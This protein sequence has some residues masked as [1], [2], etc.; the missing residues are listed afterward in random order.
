MEEHVKIY[1]FEQKSRWKTWAILN[2][3]WIALAIQE[4]DAENWAKN[5]KSLDTPGDKIA[6]YALCKMYHC[7]CYVYTKMKSWCTI[8]YNAPF[9][10]EELLSKCDIKLLLV[11][12]GVFGELKTRPYAL[13]TQLIC[14]MVKL[15]Y[16]ILTQLLC[17]AMKLSQVHWTYEQEKIG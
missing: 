7:H 13:P 9:T 1:G 4:I 10:E 6:L 2:K 12:P 14:M 15:I 8:E 17:Q 3:A 16:Q 5:I 11:E